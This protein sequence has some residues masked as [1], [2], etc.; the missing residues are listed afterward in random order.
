MLPKKLVE[1]LRAT[2]STLHTLSMIFRRLR[3]IFRVRSGLTA[4]QLSPR[5]SLRKS[6]WAAK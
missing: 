6:F 3:S 1:A 2:A 5:S 4:V